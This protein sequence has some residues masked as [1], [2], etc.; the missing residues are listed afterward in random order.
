MKI[1]PKLKYIL[2]IIGFLLPIVGLIET[3]ATRFFTLILN[4]LS[5]FLWL[6]A[7]EMLKLFPKEGYFPT[8]L[9]IPL[10]HLIVLFI[11]SGLVFLIFGYLL[12]RLLRFNF[13][14]GLI[15]IIVFLLTNIAFG[16]FVGLAY[17]VSI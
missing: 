11:I 6:L 14:L 9:K 15:L 5:Y 10:L 4:G 12:E 16:Y 13:I 3:Q 17:S 1:N 7:Q 8:T 2:A